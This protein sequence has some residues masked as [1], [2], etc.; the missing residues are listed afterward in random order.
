MSSSK[1]KTKTTGYRIYNNE[2]KER[3]KC[4]LLPDLYPELPEK[5]YD[6]IYADPPWHYNGK[7]Q[8]DNLLF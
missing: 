2:A 8:F 7:L 5:Q 6:V 1:S 4:N 3:T